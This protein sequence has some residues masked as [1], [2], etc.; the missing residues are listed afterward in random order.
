MT[1]GSSNPLSPFDFPDKRVPA[2]AA[3]FKVAENNPDTVAEVNRVSRQTGKPSDFVA[4]NLPAAKVA[5]RYTPEFWAGLDRQYPATA[6]WLARPQNM[7]VAH[8]DLENLTAIERVHN[9]FKNNLKSMG[10]AVAGMVESTGGFISALGTLDEVAGVGRVDAALGAKNT[11]P[12][13]AKSVGSGIAS[14]GRKMADFYNV[15]NP[16]FTNKLVGAATSSAVFFVPGMGIA[17][18]AAAL[19]AMPRLAAA[20]GAGFSAAF[21]AAIEAGAVHETMRQKMKAKGASD[22]EADTEALAAASKTFG[23]NIVLNSGL[24]YA[25][26]LYHKVLPG[27]KTIKGS[28]IARG[29][30]EAAQSGAAE[31]LQE[32]SQQVISNA[33]TNEPLMSGTVESAVLGGLVGGGM[34]GLVDA[35][36]RVANR[37]DAELSRQYVQELSAAVQQSKTVARSPEAL[38]GVMREIQ[39][40]P[41]LI[42]VKAFEDYWTGQGIEPAQAAKELNA[43]ESFTA[44]KENGVG[45]VMVDMAVFQSKYM[46]EHRPQLVNDIRLDPRHAT[47]NEE[48]AAEKEMGLLMQSVISETEKT[49]PGKEDLRAVRKH[50][51]AIYKANFA[52]MAARDYGEAK[53]AE[54]LDRAA[55]QAA[56]F[57]AYLFASAK[58]KNPEL[59]VDQFLKNKQRG[60]AAAQQEGEEFNQD[61]A[62]GDTSFN[63]D[64]NG[65]QYAVVELTPEQRKQ[66][67]LQTYLEDMAAVGGLTP[68]LDKLRNGRG[69]DRAKILKHGWDGLDDIQHLGVYKPG[70]MSLS[71]AAEK[72]H[73]EG[74]LEDYSEEELKDK[75]QKEILAIG[76]FKYQHGAKTY[77]RLRQQKIGDI[78]YQRLLGNTLAGQ[79][80]L[81]AA[82]VSIPHAI[83]RLIKAQRFEL[84]DVPVAQ[85]LKND[86]D[87]ADFVEKSKG[88]KMRGG[89]APLIIGYWQGRGDSVMDGWHRLA[90]AAAAGKETMPA[91]VAVS[92]TERP[93]LQPFERPLY[94]TDQGKPE[95][96]PEH[97]EVEVTKEGAVYAKPKQ[98]MTTVA[99]LKEILAAS[100]E[101]T[102]ENIKGETLQELEGNARTFITEWSG[103]ENPSPAFSGQVVKVDEGAIAYS[104]EKRSEKEQIRRLKLFKK[105]KAILENSP[106]VDRIDE[107]EPGIKRFGIAGHFSDGDVVQVVVEEK[108][109]GDKRFLSVFNVRDIKEVPRR[110]GVRG[111]PKDILPQAKR[112]VKGGKDYRGYYDPV[113]R[114]ITVGRDANASTV[115]HE[116]THD[117]LEELRL[118]VQSGQADEAVLK[119]WAAISKFLNIKKDQKLISVAQ[120]EKFARAGEMFYREGRAPVEDL[121]GAFAKLR[122]WMTSVYKEV[123]KLN[124]RLNDDVRGVFDRMLAAEEAVS[125]AELAANLNDGEISAALPAEAAAA[126]QRE[127]DLVHETAVAEVTDR[128]MEDLAPKYKEI[129]ADKRADA[130]K[131]FTAQV[132]ELPVNR[133]RKALAEKFPGRN[134]EDLAREY[135]ADNT[136]AEVETVMDAIAEAQRFASGAELA[137]RLLNYPTVEQDV[138]NRLDGYMEQFAPAHQTARVREWAVA[139]MNRDH[140][141]EVMAMESD[142]LSNLGIAKTLGTPF[143]EL[144][145]KAKGDTARWAKYHAEQEVGSMA[146]RRITS[147]LPYVTNLERVSVKI[148]QALAAKDYTAASAWLKK[149]IGIRALLMEVM[150]KREVVK[151]AV[152]YL[153]TA[154]TATETLPS[155]GKL[156]IT[157]EANEQVNKLLFR[158]KLALALPAVGKEQMTLK[159]YVEMVKARGDDVMIPDWLLTA[160]DKTRGDIKDLTVEQL[161]DLQDAVRSLKYSGHR[162]KSFSTGEELDGLAH[163]FAQRITKNLTSRPEPYDPGEGNKVLD[164]FRSYINAHRSLTWI[165]KTLDGFQ[166][167]AIS[168]FVMGK[169]RKARQNE[170][171]MKEEAVKKLDEMLSTHFPAEGN[172]PWLKWEKRRELSSKRYIIDDPVIKSLFPGGITKET[173]LMILLNQGTELNRVRFLESYAYRSRNPVDGKPEWILPMGQEHVNKIISIL[174]KDDVQFA[175]KVLDLVGSYWD[176]IAELQRV[177]TGIKPVGREAIPI[178]TQHGPIPGGYFHIAYDPRYNEQANRQSLEE[179][180]KGGAVFLAPSTRRGHTKETV[181]HVYGRRLQLQFGVIE[182]HLKDVIHDL[183]FVEPL[184]DVDMFFNHHEVVGAITNTMGRKAYQQIR[185]VLI[186]IGYENAPP[187]TITEK[188]FGTAVRARVTA[189]FLQFRLVSVL[190]QI[191]GIGPAIHSVGIGNYL[192]HL[193]AWDPT[194]IQFILDNSRIM[195]ERL[196]NRDRDVRDAIRS[197]IA[198]GPISDVQKYGFFLQGYMDIFVSLPQWMAAFDGEINRQAMAGEKINPED[199]VT[200]ADEVV[201]ANQGSGDPI[202]QS[203]MQRGGPLQ[204]L[205]SMFYTPFNPYANAELEVWDRLRE[206]GIKDM[207]H[208]MAFLTYFVILP[209]LLE[210]FLKGQM[211]DKE[212]D[213]KAWLTWTAQAMSQQTFGGWIGLRDLVNYSASGGKLGYRLTPAEGGIT[214]ALAPLIDLGKMGSNA[215]A[216]TNYNVSADKLAKDTA[217]SF[218]LML[219]LPGKQV[220][221]LAG[222]VMALLTG[223]EEAAK[224]QRV[225]YPG[226]K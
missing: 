72:F 214:T 136:P 168:K 217:D 60:L 37:K 213:D 181:R 65:K 162:A 126:L 112:N 86:P 41:V 3:Y 158:Y 11:T 177:R 182:G 194:R 30:K 73:A 215:V 18:G 19:V 69:L 56:R 34:S 200:V 133:A 166:H 74:I 188:I 148:A 43:A 123:S 197:A 5:S 103:H 212:D 68:V 223:D 21:E 209:A 124:V 107:P 29:A 8:D 57:E 137:E 171:V 225:L 157:P 39:A 216:D 89:R 221:L 146:V 98:E 145:R 114:M 116:M 139:A 52:A 105:A 192:S 199:A 27:T 20:A 82:G 198:K 169:L 48:A 120:H 46:D 222:Y 142:M 83:R 144:A 206:N 147:Y 90:A 153:E 54:V 155:G 154:G 10:G 141:L 36:H 70:G 101:L 58:R 204:Q 78:Y 189:F 22:K 106:Y 218:M 14:Y 7:A 127:R 38:E 164:G 44:A 61:S 6:R 71:E 187:S 165:C 23:A 13:I 88:E 2:E 115:F 176:Q 49:E 134:P 203:A 210:G 183:A 195:R 45:D 35:T 202:D 207:P 26:G 108:T 160:D 67:E 84:R 42:P 66:I 152:A 80:V 59:T 173:A 75:I 118:F 174:S 50:F 167:G 163:D 119:D 94:Q 55:D 129:V 40:P 53:G 47:R 161:L 102:A 128:L 62:N 111:L 81:D 100:P 79:E 151:K 180:S 190:S 28:A 95:L 93:E 25:G 24:N 135:R 104:T 109:V 125:H 99:R 77:R 226:K 140:M 1:S 219:K 185:P 63:F 211:P 138:Q 85:V 33:F 122:A 92:M 132:N 186:G 150:R 51:Q 220:D 64:E 31:F 193:K 224:P 32:G 17:R 201:Q 121:R 110:S 170:N 97:F 76:N 179:A 156:T 91:Y 87:A 184:R 175:Q 191:S 172:I 130:V 16:T 15:E 9:F 178:E 96:N 143:H 131:A 196:G 117:W 149:K 12:A 4:A 205:I 113:T 208:A 159:E